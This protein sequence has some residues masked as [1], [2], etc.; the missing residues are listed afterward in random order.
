MEGTGNVKSYHKVILNGNFHH[1]VEG[2]VY[3]WV[4]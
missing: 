4:I 1:K 2:L 3:L